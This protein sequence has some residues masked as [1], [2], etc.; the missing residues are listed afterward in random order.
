[1]KD[2]SEVARLI[3]E[4]VE[5]LEKIKPTMS[6]DTREYAKVLLA[7]HCLMDALTLLVKGEL[8]PD[9]MIW[10]SKAIRELRLDR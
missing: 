8:T 2:V 1:M 7:W 10:A 9:D 3:R 6:P 4:A 5:G